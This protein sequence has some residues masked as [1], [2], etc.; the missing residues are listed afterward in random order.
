MDT[1]EYKIIQ[2]KKCLNQV[3]WSTIQNEFIISIGLN[4]LKTLST[5]SEK[6]NS[7]TK[8]SNEIA[9][10]LG[11][12]ALKQGADILKDVLT[13]NEPDLTKSAFIIGLKSLELFSSFINEK[14]TPA[15]VFYKKAIEQFQGKQYKDSLESINSAIKKNQRSAEYFYLRGCI[16]SD[17]GN[18]NDAIQDFSQAIKINPTFT[19]AYRKRMLINYAIGNYRK[20]IR[21]ENILIEQQ[22]GDL[23]SYFRIGMSYIGLGS[24]EMALAAFN[25]AIQT[26][27][28]H[29]L[30]HLARGYLFLSKFERLHDAL[31][32]FQNV[33][34]LEP[35]CAVAYLGCARAFEDLKR[36]YESINYYSKTID[37]GICSRDIYSGRCF[38]YFLYACSYAR[39]G[40][41]K[42][43]VQYFSCSIKDYRLSNIKDERILKE[44]AKS[45]CLLYISLNQKWKARLEVY[46][47][48]LKDIQGLKL[49]VIERI[50]LAMITLL[51]SICF[52]FITTF[53]ILGY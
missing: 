26:N 29:I 38:S 25:N 30:T 45:R 40:L 32:D 34:K 33:I 9:N 8:T 12:V 15:D 21:D 52:L 4:V 50:S 14:L 3:I 7:I 23:E 36:S 39:K 47:M 2:H 6:S 24:Y 5:S 51:L 31:K 37:K 16:Y 22:S 41:H 35:N 18:F 42:K 10:E 43:A 17:I 49:T 28:S 53:L 13:L 20:A 11:Y 27:P 1:I 19:D 44:I 46:L 48:G